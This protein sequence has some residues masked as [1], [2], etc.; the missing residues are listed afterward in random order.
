MKQSHERSW[1]KVVLTKYNSRNEW[2]LSTKVLKKTVHKHCTII[3]KA[4]FL[5]LTDL[6]LNSQH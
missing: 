5:R 6:L 4:D 3:H 2:I 1:G